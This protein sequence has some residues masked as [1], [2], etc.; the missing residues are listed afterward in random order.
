[1]YLPAIAYILFNLCKNKTKFI[2]FRYNVNILFY[3]II[4]SHHLIISY[5]FLVGIQKVLLYSNLRKKYTCLDILFIN[6]S[7][8]NYYP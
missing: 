7:K 2:S 5:L 6:K 3:N 8:T 1:M 4:L